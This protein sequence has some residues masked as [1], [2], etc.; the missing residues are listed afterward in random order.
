M[1]ENR[2]KSQEDRLTSLLLK[3]EICELLHHEADLLDDHRFDEWLALLDDDITYTMPLRLNVHHSDMAR[4]MTRSGETCWF[5]DTKVEQLQTGEHWAEEP[6]SRVSHV[7]SN[8]RVLSIDDGKPDCGLTG[9]SSV[10]VGCRFLVYRNRVAA[11]TD[12]WV[13]R[14][15]DSWKATANGWRLHRRHLLLDQNV[16]SSKNL[17]V[18]F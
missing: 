5:D 6:M 1:S 11:E 10:E 9:P 13:G 2:T 3:D 18:L 8:I 16:L 17:T 12:L 4:S 15:T 14:R 7:V